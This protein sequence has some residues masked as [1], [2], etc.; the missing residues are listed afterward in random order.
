MA[1][2][3]RTDSADSTDVD[4]VSAT[5]EDSEDGVRK[6]HAAFYEAWPQA[7]WPA[8]LEGDVLMRF[9]GTSQDVSDNYNEIQLHSLSQLKHSSL[10][11][12]ALTGPFHIPHR[13]GQSSEQIPLSNVTGQ[14]R[15]TYMRTANGAVSATT[16]RAYALALPAAS[17]CSFD[18]ALLDEFIDEDCLFHVMLTFRALGR[19]YISSGSALLVIADSLSSTNSTHDLSASDISS[20]PRPSHEPFH[21]RCRVA[22]PTGDSR[23]TI[24]LGECCQSLGS[25][26]LLG[27]P[28]RRRLRREHALP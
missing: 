12:L 19:P 4:E 2:R 8:E 23:K 13:S 6:S 3:K 5:A 7:Q 24:P 27:Q 15:L 21:V 17:D 10:S 25:I 16:T 9:Y 14:W 26:R 22:I 20:V 1:K 11:G 18:C 28:V